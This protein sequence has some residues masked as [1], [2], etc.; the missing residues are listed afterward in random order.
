MTLF[1]DKLILCLHMLYIFFYHQ[2]GFVVCFTRWFY[3]FVIMNTHWQQSFVFW[4]WAAA[5]GGAS[6][7]P[8]WTSSSSC[9]FSGTCISCWCFS[10]HE[11]WAQIQTVTI[12]R[13]LFICLVFP[14]SCSL[15]EQNWFLAISLTFLV[16]RK[17]H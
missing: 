7:S 3:L 5:V 1:D 12:L 8:F 13:P 9:R 16:K 10:Q 2:V 17:G 6:E 4:G 11:K 15:I 14:P